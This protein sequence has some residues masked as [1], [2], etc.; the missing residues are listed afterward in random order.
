MTKSHLHGQKPSLGYSKNPIHGH[1]LCENSWQAKKKYITILITD[2]NTIAETSL[3]LFKNC[4]F[5]RALQF[6]ILWNCRSGGLGA[7]TIGEF[8]K[9]LIALQGDDGGMKCVRRNGL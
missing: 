2:F 6:G 7:E 1:I 5:A 8:V 3:H 9:L 4:V